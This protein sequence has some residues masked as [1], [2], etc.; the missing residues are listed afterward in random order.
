MTSQHHFPL[1]SVPIQHRK[2]NSLMT[3]NFPLPAG[4]HLGRLALRNSLG[5][6]RGAKGSRPPNQDLVTNMRSAPALSLPGL[7]P[8]RPGQD[9]LPAEG[10]SRVRPQVPTPGGQGL[11][12]CKQHVWVLERAVTGEDAPRSREGSAPWR[13]PLYSQQPPPPASTLFSQRDPAM[14]MSDTMAVLALRPHL[15]P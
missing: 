1:R 12:A 3:S 6:S 14:W 11:D 13:V 2:V 5:E 8:T 4:R 15:P 10:S 9:Y 7:Q